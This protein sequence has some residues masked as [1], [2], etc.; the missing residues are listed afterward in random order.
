ML[1]QLALTLFIV[2]ESQNLSRSLIRTSNVDFYESFVKPKKF[3]DNVKGLTIYSE[4]KD[5][6]GN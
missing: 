3:N 4:E 5:I 6:K 1:L 2:P